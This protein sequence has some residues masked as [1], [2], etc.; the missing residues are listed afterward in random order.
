MTLFDTATVFWM[1]FEESS[2]FR[3]VRLG[4][5]PQVRR[6]LVIRL[7]MPSRCLADGAGRVEDRK[8][9]I[10]QVVARSLPPWHVPAETDVPLFFRTSNSPSLSS[11][12]QGIFTFHNIGFSKTVEEGIRCVHVTPF[13]RG[14]WLRGEG[15]C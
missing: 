15:G 2:G 13:P 7:H 3:W 8:E 1:F 12:V 6:G 14:H 5:S 10:W 11:T 9:G 4:R